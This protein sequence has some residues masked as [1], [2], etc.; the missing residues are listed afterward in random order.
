M[1]KKGLEAGLYWT[2]VFVHSYSRTNMVFRCVFVKRCY[3]I[4]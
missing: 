1:L 3:L 4:W 2:A